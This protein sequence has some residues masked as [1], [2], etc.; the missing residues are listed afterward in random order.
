MDTFC[1]SADRLATRNPCGDVKSLDSAGT[2]CASKR[3]P[4]EMDM[5]PERDGHYIV[6]VLGTMAVAS[7][8]EGRPNVASRLLCLIFFIWR[9]YQN[10]GGPCT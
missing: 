4:F 3:A 1:F 2:K 7:T 6:R 10:E 5:T 9:K 8:R